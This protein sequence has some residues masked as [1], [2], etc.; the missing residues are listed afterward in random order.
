MLLMLLTIVV[1]FLLSTAGYAVVG[2]LALRRISKRITPEGKKALRD[3][4]EFVLPLLLFE[5]SREDKEV[6]P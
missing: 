4:N 3:V 2:W 6:T 1:T 5:V